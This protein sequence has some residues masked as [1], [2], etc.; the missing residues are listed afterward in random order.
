MG[1]GCGFCETM[2]SWVGVAVQG[3]LLKEVLGRKVDAKE[4]GD[5]EATSTLGEATCW[6][7]PPELQT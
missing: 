5:G 6:T 2:H 7:G 1:L 3:L 4:Q